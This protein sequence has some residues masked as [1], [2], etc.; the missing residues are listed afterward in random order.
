MT[1]A[2]PDEHFAAHDFTQTKPIGGGCTADTVGE[3]D[4]LGELLLSTCNCVQ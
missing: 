4:L 2:V 3:W 1:H